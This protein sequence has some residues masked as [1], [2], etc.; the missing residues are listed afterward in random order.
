MKHF[1]FLLLLTIHVCV[2]RKLKAKPRLGG[3]GK[4]EF[5]VGEEY[6]RLPGAVYKDPE[7]M[8]ES[9]S[10]VSQHQVERCGVVLC[11]VRCTWYF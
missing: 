8:V 7:A 3:E 10:N 1:A 2:V 9:G 6:S 5:E 11:C 4:W